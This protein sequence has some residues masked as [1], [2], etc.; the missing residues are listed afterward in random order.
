VHGTVGVDAEAVGGRLVV[1]RDTE[2]LAKTVVQVRKSGSRVGFKLKLRVSIVVNENKG[3][4][5]VKSS[6]INLLGNLDQIS[7][8][9]AALH[10][11]KR[12]E[13]A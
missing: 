7:Q 1:P 13:P 3:G 10:N 12:K 2:F 4:F 11:Q 8:G 6:E 5:D 9:H